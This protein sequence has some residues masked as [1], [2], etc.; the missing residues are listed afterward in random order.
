MKKYAKRRGI[1]VTSSSR[2]RKDN[3]KNICHKSRPEL[4]E[5]DRYQNMRKV[6]DEE[7][8]SMILY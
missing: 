4:S 3:K 7:I 6:T 8:D 2:Q 5:I 1:V